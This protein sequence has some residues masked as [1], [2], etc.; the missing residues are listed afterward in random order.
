[1]RAQFVG[2]VVGE[3]D[4]VDELVLGDF[5]DQARPMRGART[6][7][8]QHLRDRQFH[9]RR[10]RRVDRELDRRAVAGE[11][12]PVV[13]RREDHLF[14]QR[15]HVGFGR[16]GQELIGED[17]AV[18]G[19]PHTDQPFGAG[20]TLG[21]EIDFRLIPEFEP[22]V[23]DRL[24]QRDFGTAAF[25]AAQSELLHGFLHRLR[26]D[27]AAARPA[28][29]SNSFVRP[30]AATGRWR[31]PAHRCAPRMGSPAGSRSVWARPRA[32]RSP[33]GSARR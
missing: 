3:I 32:P 21:G 30:R 9:Q 19:M 7:L 24:L 27:K 22:V 25:V 10:D 11:F 13:Q 6:L 33:H 15:Q 14:G 12:V 28:S 29:L 20:E 31:R 2:D 5:E 23:L 4:V 1:M 18:F 8:A 17:H 26:P 16:A